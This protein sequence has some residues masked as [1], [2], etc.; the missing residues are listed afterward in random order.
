MAVSSSKNL[1]GEFQ[2][3][4]EAEDREFEEHKAA[5]I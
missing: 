4:I 3:E 1:L 5:M 2:A